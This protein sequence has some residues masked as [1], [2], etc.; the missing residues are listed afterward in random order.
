MVI[1][2]NEDE[3]GELYEDIGQACLAAHD[4]LATQLGKHDTATV[5]VQR[6]TFK[7]YETLGERA[8]KTSFGA[9]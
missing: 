3:P 2:E 8:E 1:T 5:V 4:A 7:V 9:K 6:V